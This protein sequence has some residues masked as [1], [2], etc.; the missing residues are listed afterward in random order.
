MKGVRFEAVSS[1]EQTVTKE[2][3][4][5]R[6]EVFFFEHSICYVIDVIVLLKQARTLLSDC[7]N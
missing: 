6:V 4:D 5:I 3:N 7:T 1:I 2:V